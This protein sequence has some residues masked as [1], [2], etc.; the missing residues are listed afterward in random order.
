MSKLGLRQASIR[1]GERRVP[2]TVFAEL[3]RAGLLEKTV[4]IEFRTRG[5][6]EST[7]IYRL[8]EGDQ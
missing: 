7:S 6:V 8:R 2:F 4:E 3:I 1:L 5:S